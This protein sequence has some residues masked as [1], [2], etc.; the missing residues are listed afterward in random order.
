LYATVFSIN[1]TEEKKITKR[2]S[3]KANHKNIITLKK[4]AGFFVAKKYTFLKDEKKKKHRYARKKKE[5]KIALY[6]KG[7]PIIKKYKK[8]S[9]K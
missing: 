2:T 9:S 1:F 7:V 8:F 6:K 5:K 4:E 3:L